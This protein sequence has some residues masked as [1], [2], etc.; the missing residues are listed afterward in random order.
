VADDGFG[1]YHLEVIADQRSLI[2]SSLPNAPGWHLA[3]D[4]ITVPIE[5]VNGAFVG[6]FVPGGRSQIVL[7]YRP[8]SFDLGLLCFVLAEMCVA[9]V[10][11]RG[12]RTRRR[13][14]LLKRANGLAR[15][16]RRQNEQKSHFVQEPPSD[17]IPTNHTLR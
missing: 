17:S 8:R 1:V 16:G 5:T 7:R 2:V 4:R 15:V 11:I 3:I 6:F 12:I 14:D 10:W 9:A 13:N